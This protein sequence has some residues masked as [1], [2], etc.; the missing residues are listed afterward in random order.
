MYSF[1]PM[2]RLL[3]SIK[4]MEDRGC[5]DTTLLDEKML[6]DTP[7]E[8]DRMAVRLLHEGLIDGL[9]FIDGING[10]RASVILYFPES[11]IVFEGMMEELLK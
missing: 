3:A 10:Q 11:Y 9:H 6:L 1:K 2:A 8:R 5:V 7:D 4:A